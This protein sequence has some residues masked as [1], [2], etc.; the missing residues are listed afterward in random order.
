MQK[1]KGTRRGRLKDMEPSFG[2]I[3][4]SNTG[5]HGRLEAEKNNNEEEERTSLRPALG[6][7]D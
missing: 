2:Y 7:G 6:I 1:K 3:S 4:G 5:N